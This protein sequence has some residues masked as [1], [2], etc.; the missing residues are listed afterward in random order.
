[1]K[2]ISEGAALRPSV[3]YAA[4]VALIL[5]AVLRSAI[6]TRTDGFTIDEAY[7]IT[8]G[9]SYVKLRD[10]RLNPEHPP[11]VKLWVGC[12]LAPRFNL[13]PLRPLQDKGAERNFNES[14]VFL[15]NDPDRVQA[16]AR[17]AMWIL[18]GAL[19]LFLALA[20]ARTLGNVAALA[21][22]AFLAIDPT[23]AAHLPVVLTDLPVALTASTAIL[24]AVRAFRTGS[25]LDTTLAAFAL[26]L[27]LG[28]K[29]SGVITVLVVGALGIVAIVR[30]RR[31]LLTMISIGA[32]ALIVLWALYGFRY[33]E[34]P[35][36]QEAF[37][38]PLA[39]KIQ[40]VHSSASRMALRAMTKVHLVPRS[41]VWG[42]ADTMRTGIEGRGISVYFFGR[43][44]RDRGPVYYF[45]TVLAAKLPL[46]L[47][48]LAVS[49]LLLLA[50]R[51]I[52]NSWELPAVAVLLLGG[53]F[54]IALIRGV[55]YGGVRHA[56]P[57]LIVL[58]LFGGMTASLAFS[59]GSRGIRI[60]V[61]IAAIAAV[62]SAVPKIRP[63]E[64]FN[65]AAGGPDGGYLHFGD[66][67]VDMGQRQLDFVRYYNARLK[68]SGTIPYLFYPM[69]ISEQSARKVRAR[70]NRGGEAERSDL[71]LD[72]T[73]IFFVRSSTIFKN[74]RFEVFSKAHPAGRIGNLLIYNGTFHLPWLRV[75][76]LTSRV[77]RILLSPNP[78]LNA[79]ET[80]LREA[81]N[82]NPRNFLA[83]LQSA[84][85][86]LREGHRAEAK[87]FY[88]RALE[89][90][91][92]DEPAMRDALNAQIARLSS[93][94][95]IEHI[96]PVRGT[97]VE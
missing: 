66:E 29:H 97:R 81:L 46:G 68:S 65:E 52:P 11:L 83:L 88:Q 60:L 13:P 22:V 93:N 72:V 10:F 37:N 91:G 2:R 25:W 71:Q 14:A 73:G 15:N 94:E 12:L 75:N 89:Q 5:L 61:L 36:G 4:I 90:V 78:D 32:G 55:S 34:T 42:L 45:P 47:L 50:I 53:A 48:A 86:M 39:L 26:G 58:A 35:S 31:A 70:G 56:L 41:Y 69:S 30:R 49:G 76:K 21:T 18:N 17:V 43:T 63:W 54:L 96:Q 82:I 23:I 64:Y 80:T 6:A 24:F 59:S 95:P 20:I 84:N 7:H 1:L 9:V 67:G 40:D 27:A 8:A 92:D 85:L 38:R 3:A 28:A 19:I 62:V 16:Q 87:A 51:K 74:P 77:S 33:A 57:I 79:A 44:F